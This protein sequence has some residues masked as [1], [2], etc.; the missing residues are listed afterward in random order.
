MAGSAPLRSCRQRCR[1]GTRAAPKGCLRRQGQAAAAALAPGARAEQQ[2]EQA[3]KP[4]GSSTPGVVY[5][6]NLARETCN[7]APACCSC[8]QL[9][10][11]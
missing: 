7:S 4:W 5:Q 8:A 2:P 10:A 1:C 3:A 9:R 11:W 6:V